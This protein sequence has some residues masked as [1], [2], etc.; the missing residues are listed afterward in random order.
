MFKTVA[1][2][3]WN[4]TL[5]FFVVVVLQTKSSPQ[6]DGLLLDEF[7]QSVSMSTYLVAFIVANLSNVSR[8]VNGTQV[9][10]TYQS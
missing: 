10:C 7:E 1:L 2:F 3:S 8:D 6:Q 9:G 5:P 4:T